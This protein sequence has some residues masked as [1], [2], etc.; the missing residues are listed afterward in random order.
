MWSLVTVS[1]VLVYR[2]HYAVYFVNA[3]TGVGVNEINHSTR[4]V[5]CFPLPLLFFLWMPKKG[6]LMLQRIRPGIHAFAREIAMS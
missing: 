6:G 3:I 1:M 5:V 4:S 2:E